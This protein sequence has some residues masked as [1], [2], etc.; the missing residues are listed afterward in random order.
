M[1]FFYES[2]TNLPSNNNNEGHLY[3]YKNTKV[4]ILL[5]QTCHWIGLFCEVV[6]YNQILLPPNLFFW[7]VHVL[8][9]DIP[10]FTKRTL[11]L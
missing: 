9:N 4:P 5:I 7:E 3:M 1:I 8:I 10:S 11:F 6:S 2:T